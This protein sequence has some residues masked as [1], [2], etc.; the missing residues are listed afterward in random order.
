MI[1]GD[2]Q[3]SIAP[4]L[5]E[6]SKTE[7]LAGGCVRVVVVANVSD[8]TIP[9]EKVV[10]ASVTDGNRGVGHPDH[11]PVQASRRDRV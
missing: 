4:R 6:T 9:E 7:R 10:A 5:G 2:G 8:G 3:A 11:I 1:W